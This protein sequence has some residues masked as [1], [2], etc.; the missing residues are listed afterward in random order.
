L[1]RKGLRVQIPSFAPDRKERI[2]YGKT[3][4]VKAAVVLLVMFGISAFFMLV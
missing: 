3:N 2:V 1:S 4:Y